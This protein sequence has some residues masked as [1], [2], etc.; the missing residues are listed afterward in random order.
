[1]VHLP[2]SGA[3]VGWW[4]TCRLVVHLPLVVPLPVSGALAG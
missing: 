2:V 1:M 4:C 3:L